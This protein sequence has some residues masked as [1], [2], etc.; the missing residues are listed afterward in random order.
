MNQIARKKETEQAHLCLGFEGLQVG[1]E[2]IYSLI[3]LNNILGGSMSSRLFQD[4]REQRGLAYSVFSYHSAFEDTW[5][6]DY[7]WW[8]RGKTARFLI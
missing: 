2:D 5:D 7:I 3:T 6:C 8:D 4:V 1:H